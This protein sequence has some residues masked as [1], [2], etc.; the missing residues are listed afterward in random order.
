VQPGRYR[1]LCLPLLVAGADGAP[2]R[3]LLQRL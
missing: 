1:L 3:T 2:A